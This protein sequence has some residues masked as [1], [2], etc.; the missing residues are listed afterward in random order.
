MIDINDFDAI[1]IGLASSKQIR[2]WSSGEVTKPET[3]NY[4]TLKPE[5][6]G[7][8]C[9]R[10]FGPTKDWEC[11]CGK[12]KRVRYKGIICERCG[13]EVTR[14]KVRRERMGHIDLAAPVSHIWFFKG[15]P[16]R[17]GYLLDIAPRE[18]EKVLYFAASIVTSVDVEKRAA[19]LADLEDKVAAE[20]E[21][22]YLDRD[23]ALAALDD[24]LARRREYFATGKERNFDEDDDFW[25][26]GL[27]NW[28]EETGQPTLEEVRGLAGGVFVQLARTVTHEDSRRIRELVRQ[29]ATREDRRLAPREVEAVAAAATQIQAAL[30]PLRADLEKATGSKKGAVTKHIKRLQEALAAGAELSPEDAALVEAVDKRNL[31]RARE[32]GNGLLA[33]VLAAADPEADPAAVRELAYDL[34]LVE[35]TRKEDLD[36][37]AQ[38]AAKVREMVADIDVRREDTREAAVEAVRRLEQTWILFKELEPKMIVGDEQI[39]RE[40]KDR[41]GSP[42]GFGVYFRG[43]MGAE[44]VRDLLRDLDLEAE[45]RALREVIKTSK[46]QK[47]QRAIKRLKVVEAFIKSGNKPEWM[48]LEAIPVIPPELRPMVQL[49]GGRFATSDLNDLYRRVINR[50]NRLKRLLD[51]GAPEIIV[52]N[53]KRMLQ[54]AV[55]ALFDNGRRGRAVTGPGNRPLKSLSDMLKGKQGRFRQNL[56][57]KRVDYS[58]RSV[59]VAGPNLKLHQCGLPKLMALELFKPFIMSRLVERKAVQNIKAAKKMVESMI[60]EVWDVLEEVIAEHPVLLNRAPTLHRLGIQAF[61]PVLVEGK[62]IQ[63]HPLVCHAYNADFDGDQMA[64]H[65]PLSAEAQAEAR[66]LMLSAHNILSPASGRPLATPTQDMVLGAYFLTYCEHDLEG[67]SA[68]ELAKTLGR[69]GLPRFRAEEDVELAL[70]AGQIGYQDPIEYDWH[71]E[72]LLTTP[73]RVIFNAEVERAL[74]EA[75]GDQFESPPFQNRSL[76]KRELDAF[77]AD[78]VERYGATTIASALDVIKSLTFRFATRAGITI[79][80]NDIVIPPNKE[81]ILQKYEEEVA[82]VGREYDRGLMTEEER[83][84]R[85]VAI[86][87]KATDEV[88]DAMMANFSPTNPIFMMANSGARG[89]FNQ[90]RQLAGM[91]GLMADPKGEI[92]TRPIKANF[93][94]GLTVLEYFISTHGARKGLA[95]TALR[96]AD[97]GYLTRRLV[98]VSQDVIVREEDCGT[99]EY[100]E[101][102]LILDDAPNKNVAGRVAARD[103]YKPLKDGKPGK[104]VLVEKGQEIT[105][106]GLR[107]LVAEFGEHAETARIPVRSVLKCRS[108]FG[109]C[110]LCYGTFLATGSLAEIGDAVGIIAAQSIGEPGTQLTMRTFHTGG[111]AGVADITHGLPRVVEIFEA[112]NPKGAATLAEIAGKVSVEEQERSLKVTIT[113][114]ALDESGE[115]AE[116]R[117]YSFPRRTRLLVHDGQTVEA[118]DPLNEGSLNPADLLLLKGSTPTELYLVDEVQKVYKSQGVEIHDKHIELIVRQMLKKVRV[119]SAGDT[120]LLPGQLVDR[121]QVERENARVQEEGGELATYEPVILGIT[122]ASLATESFLSAASF[123]ETTKV[124]TDAAIEGK[125]DRLQGLKE[126][127]IIGKLIPAATGLKRYRQIAIEPTEPLPVT[128]TRPEAEA[129]LLAALEEIGEGDGLD[130]EGLDLGLGGGSPSGEAEAAELEQPAEEE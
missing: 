127:V 8:F 38:W 107:R 74:A 36:A 123:Q 45:S 11:Y 111:V 10:I 68:E 79:S 77:I 91:R 101:L 117:E 2:D 39:F 49:D 47:Q 46:G 27:S 7:L 16:S 109:L 9:E 29:A 85:I 41:F 86:W 88:A 128:F 95:D 52:N 20:Q 35:G 12:Y 28:A 125:I 110:R 119:E 113:P 70:E 89:S 44:A 112:R 22:I 66:V 122:K 1:R 55:D 24:R 43:G 58:G 14:Q 5:R 56:L 98:D 62:A 94:E 130:L 40:L 99:E 53:E 34:C 6:D 17:I 73:G 93:M 50:N 72:R 126:N 31:E 4:R 65:L 75:A 78:L 61:E 83:D 76:T 15:V 124:L 25:A 106:G 64:V 102:P 33:D 129:E 32:V 121:V 120:S 51:L 114:T 103:V 19:D 104:T 71:G 108:E 69:P 96:T 81:E 3:I 13:V 57:G 42:Y 21:R 116:P 118:G 26:R 37:I 82:K 48:I 60:P 80:K 59:I 105:L 23:E 54:E 115:L 30:A 84:E 92:I 97:S 87:T 90:I 67:T 18:L 100:I 63:I